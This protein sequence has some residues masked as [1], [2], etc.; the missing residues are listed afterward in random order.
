[1]S[2][3]AAVIEA[4]VA[5]KGQRPCFLLHPPH[6]SLAVS[7]IADMWELTPRKWKPEGREDEDLLPFH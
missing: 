4:Q 1:M 6:H 5:T 7:H 3:E 2:A